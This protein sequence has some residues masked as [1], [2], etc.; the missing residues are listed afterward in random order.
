[1][2]QRHVLTDVIISGT[3]IGTNRATVYLTLI[4]AGDAGPRIVAATMAAQLAPA[5]HSSGRILTAGP[6][7]LVTESRAALRSALARGSAPTGA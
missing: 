7:E 6:D 3:S 1:V 2:R 4:A 5:C